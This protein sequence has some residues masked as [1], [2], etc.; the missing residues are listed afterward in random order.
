MAKITIYNLNMMIDL[1]S[2]HQ[3]KARPLGEG[4]I[5]N[6]EDHTETE[7]TDQSCPP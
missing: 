4:V 2:G 3:W 6:T 1:N 7:P 5:R